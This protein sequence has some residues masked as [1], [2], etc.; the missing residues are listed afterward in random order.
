MKNETYEFSLENYITDLKKD[1]IQKPTAIFTKQNKELN[2]LKNYNK[3]INKINNFYTYSTEGFSNFIQMIKDAIKKI[4]VLIDT[5]IKKM[6]AKFLEI[7]YKSKNGLYKKLSNTK[8]SK[9]KINLKVKERP[10]NKR[11]LRN[12]DEELENLDEFRNISFDDLNY[13]AKYNSY[14]SSQ[15]FDSIN[16]IKK[17][18]TDIFYDSNKPNKENIDVC[19]FFQIRS[20]STDHPE[21]FELLSDEY[22]KKF[23]NMKNSTENFLKQVKNQYNNLTKTDTYKEEE[24]Y[25]TG[26]KLFINRITY[27]YNFIYRFFIESVKVRSKIAKYIIC[28]Y[29]GIKLEE[30]TGD[31]LRR[32]ELDKFYESLA[33][34]K[35]NLIPDFSLSQVHK[36]F[37]NEYPNPE[38]MKKKFEELDEELYKCKDRNSLKHKEIFKEIFKLVLP[39]DLANQLISDQ[40]QYTIREISINQT[41]VFLNIYLIKY[42]YDLTNEDVLYH[43]SER[44]NLTTLIG[45]TKPE[46]DMIYFSSQR[47][48]LGLNSII[49][50]VGGTSLLNF[51]KRNKK[52]RVYKVKDKLDIVY[53]DPELNNSG[54]VFTD[55]Q[56]VQ[57]EDIT[58][59]FQSLDETKDVDLGE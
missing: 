50:R 38:E 54:A 35:K 34:R 59:L 31:E 10:L 40:I 43:T 20:D 25:Y 24:K 13:E 17:Y 8:G 1:F 56:S 29:S 39:E 33:M 44:P 2:L 46:E 4:I 47:I 18:I 9:V 23:S 32:K 19:D 45:T 37:Y 14:S 7:T 11:L 3:L 42:A 57:V 48:F 6:I 5:L 12:I 52:I 27:I 36:K 58:D 49:Q 51:F 15:T 41:H 30:L 55:K 22:A 21:A 53:D 26:L 28:M 16:G